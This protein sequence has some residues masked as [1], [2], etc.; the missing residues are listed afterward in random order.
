MLCGKDNVTFRL[1]PG[2]NHMFVTA[3]SDRITDS[4]NEYKDS[5]HIPDD[6]IQTI[7]DWIF[8]CCEAK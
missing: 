7:S 3:K 5:R 6:V 8:Q 1:F 2:L 4:K